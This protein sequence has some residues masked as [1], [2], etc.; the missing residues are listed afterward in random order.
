MTCSIAFGSSLRAEAA[1]LRPKLPDGLCGLKAV[2]ILI[3]LNPTACGLLFRILHSIS[4]RTRKKRVKKKELWPVIECGVMREPILACEVDT[5][6]G[7]EVSQQTL[8]VHIP[9]L[10]LQLPASAFFHQ[11]AFSSDKAPLSPLQGRPE[12]SGY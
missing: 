6:E 12:V 7:V 2:S 10:S 1:S 8:L 9:T 3:S 11:R 4:V 5:R